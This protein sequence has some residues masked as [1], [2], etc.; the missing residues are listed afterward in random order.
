[1]TWKEYYDK[2]YDWSESEQKRRFY[3]LTD[4]GSADEVYE[5][6][7][8]FENPKYSSKLVNR[9]LDEGI[10]FNPEDILDFSNILDKATLSRA[11]ETSAS[12]FDRYELEEISKYVDRDVFERAAK[13]SGT[14]IFAED[15]EE[16]DEEDDYDTYDEFDDIDDESYEEDLSENTPSFGLFNFIGGIFGALFS[17][18]GKPQSEHKHKCDHDC[19]NCPE[20]YGYR[21]G[22]W[23]YGRHHIYGCE[24]GGN[25]NY[26]DPMD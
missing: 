19:K 5:I 24:F 16:D 2:F 10:R 1:M 8:E 17:E 4:I 13:R 6:A 12:P 21:Y 11:V 22:R 20:H 14:D 15:D 7:F 3:D 18:L 25:N 9:A 23:Y 26:N